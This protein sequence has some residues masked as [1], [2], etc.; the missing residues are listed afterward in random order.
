LRLIACFLFARDRPV[1]A[2]AQP[3]AG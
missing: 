2:A 3:A 1:T